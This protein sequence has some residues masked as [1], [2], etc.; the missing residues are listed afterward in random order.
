MIWQ[1][2]QR[3]VVHH[4]LNRYHDRMKLILVLIL[5]LGLAYPL[6]RYSIFLYS[7]WRA[8][9]LVEIDK[10]L[11]GLFLPILRGMITAGIADLIVTITYPLGI[12]GGRE[13]ME[14]G[15]PVVLVHGLFHNSSALLTM[16]KRLRKAGIEN[17]HTYQ[18]NSL[19]GEFPEAM[20][21]L[22]RKLDKLL[23]EAPE[24]KVMLVGHSL[25]G[26]VIRAA[27]GNPRFWGKVSG[28]ITLGSPHGGSE[29]ARF[30]TNPMGRGLIPGHEIMQR[31]NSLPDPNCPK[32]AI[33]TLADD[34][35]L[36]LETLL[37]PKTDWQEIECSPMG[38]IWMLY[39]QEVS[40]YV[41]DFLIKSDP[42]VKGEA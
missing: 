20:E 24:G 34:Y 37:P 11:G 38:H 27:V 26:L 8:G 17:T 7:N 41:I 35:V 39:S 36:P 28:L 10:R 9:S 15:T 25:G 30:A 22:Q 31:A 1:K 23:R 18:Y 4:P 6:V 16:K 40:D 33:Y 3:Q 14:K 13:P 2:N 5:F 21:G 32:L 12:F 19:W 29:L 42:R